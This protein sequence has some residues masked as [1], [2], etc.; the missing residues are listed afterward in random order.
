MQEEKWYKYEMKAIIKDNNI[1]MSSYK[2][3]TL[4]YILGLEETIN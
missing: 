2:N 1:K 4:F 3:T